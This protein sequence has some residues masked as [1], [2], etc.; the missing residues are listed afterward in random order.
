MQGIIGF[1]LQIAAMSVLSAV[2]E[3]LVPDGPL[4]AARPLASDSYL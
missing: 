3:Q 1:S 4:N 2:F